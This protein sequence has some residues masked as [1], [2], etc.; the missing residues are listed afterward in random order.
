MCRSLIGSPMRKKRG[1]QRQTIEHKRR[2]YLSFDDD[3]GS[4]SEEDEDKLDDSGS[5]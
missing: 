1:N 5:E 2:G 3:D 4:D